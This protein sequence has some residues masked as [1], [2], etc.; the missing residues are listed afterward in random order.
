MKFLFVSHL[1]SPTNRHTSHFYL[2]ICTFFSFSTLFSQLEFFF[3]RV[4]STFCHWFEELFC[5]LNKNHCPD[6]IR[7][8]TPF[9]LSSSKN[10]LSP[11]GII[12]RVFMSNKCQLYLDLYCKQHNNHKNYPK[13]TSH[14]EKSIKGWC[15]C[16]KNNSLFPVVK[17]IWH[18]SNSKSVKCIIKL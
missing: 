15:E 11:H 2:D 18:H 10:V 7:I 12:W 4:F 6:A 3:S 17:T 9:L 1:L 8:F 16:T 13:I 14:S 5:E